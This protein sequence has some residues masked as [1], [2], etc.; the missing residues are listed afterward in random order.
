MKI[1][2][3]NF[4]HNN[5]DIIIFYTFPKEINNDTKIMLV[6]S[7]CLRDAKEYMKNWKIVSKLSNTIVI[8]PELK[9]EEYDINEYNY[10]NIINNNII[11]YYSEWTFNI[12]DLIFV[13]FTKKFN[14]SNKKYILY[15]HSAGSQFVHRTRMF[16]NGKYLDYVIAANAGTYTILNENLDYPYGIGNLM[17][18]KGKILDNLS[19]KMYILVGDLDVDPNHKHF[20]TDKKFDFEGEHRFKRAQYF[21]NTSKLYS[22]K[23]DVPFNWKLIVMKNVEHEN[24]DTIKYVIDIID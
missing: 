6:M 11:N 19:E 7:G 5:K 16:Y 23:N 24:K 2:N 3:Y 17:R 15:G 22:E 12:L 21:Y 13:D 14:L 20:P 9:E 8:C 18:Y 4:K 1:N 10:I